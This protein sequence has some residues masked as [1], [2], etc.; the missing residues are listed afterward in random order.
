MEGSLHVRGAAGDP[1]GTIRLVVDDLQALNRAQING[2]TT[3]EEQ[4]LNRPSQQFVEE[5]MI[6]RALGV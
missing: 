1:L 6:G 5:A 2:V 4:V 3:V